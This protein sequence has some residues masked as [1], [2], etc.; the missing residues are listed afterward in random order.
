[1]ELEFTKSAYSCL[2]QVVHEVQNM[3]QTQEIKLSD[4]FPDIGRVISAWGQAV[5]RSKEWRSD[6]FLISGGMI[7]WIMYQAE[8]ENGLR[9]IDSWIPFQMKW[10]LPDNTVDG[11]IRICCTTRFVDARSVSPRKIMV[12][13]GVGAMG[14]AYVPMEYTV[15]MPQSVPSEFEVLEKKQV[16]KLPMEAGERSFPVEDEITVH[17]N[18]SAP[19][20]VV[21]SVMRPEISDQK[22]VGNKI[23][24]RGNGNLH[25][26][27]MDEEGKVY[28]ED[29]PVPFSQFA[30][31]D[32]TYG[33]NASVS[34]YP[35][36]T[37]LETE[38]QDSGS[39]ALKANIAA[40][41]LVSEEQNV[42][43]IEDAYSPGYAVE[44]EKEMLQLPAISEQRRENLPIEI[45]IPNGD[46]TPADLLLQMDFSRDMQSETGT[47]I[48][49]S[50]SYQILGYDSNMELQPIT[51]HWESTV[52]IKNRNHDRINL[53]AFPPVEPQLAFSGNSG[54]IRED[55]PMDITFLS[56][57]G[58]SV[59]TECRLGEPK[60]MDQSRPSLII[61][62][63][64]NTDLWKLAKETGSTVRAIRKANKL[65]EEPIRGQMIIIP[66]S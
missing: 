23:A 14:E 48:Y 59:I 26:L 8:Q 61:C 60:E 49:T 30:E 16:L 5:V 7:V 28:A 62:R 11:K 25:I 1:M 44:L 42:E 52:P 63:A 10:D 22:V 66:I 2:N 27:F 21:Y 3:E 9:M 36:L 37:S 20:K 55:I 6:S 45:S 33:S 56:D 24:F 15:S 39:V 40:Q 47:D 64:E 31:L 38:V 34:V 54:K 65:E 35:C 18:G 17:Q 13:A 12:R 51:G 53:D 50:G 32:T 41:Y 4:G 46:F 19:G 58:I 43:Y 57:N 29:Y